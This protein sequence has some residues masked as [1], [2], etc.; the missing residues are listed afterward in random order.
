ML[1][2]EESLKHF[3]IRKIDSPALIES[4]HWKFITFQT[5]D[6]KNVERVIK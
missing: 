5:N 4:F 6:E 2:K 1:E 3:R